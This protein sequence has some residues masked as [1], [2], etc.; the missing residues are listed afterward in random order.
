MVTKCRRRSRKLQVNRRSSAALR[1]ADV[2]GARRGSMPRGASARASP[3]SGSA[4]DSPRTRSRERAAFRADRRGAKPVAEGSRADP[5]ESLARTVPVRAGGVRRVP[6]LDSVSAP[7]PRLRFT[8]E[9]TIDSALGF[10]RARRTTD[11]A[12]KRGL[13]IRGGLLKMTMPDRS[14][15]AASVAHC[16][17][18]FGEGAGNQ[19]S[20][21]MSPPNLC[22]IAS[23]A[24]PPGKP[25]RQRRELFAVRS[26]QH[27]LPALRRPTT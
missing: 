4:A 16:R 18:R 3:A 19:P 25:R 12:P 20:M 1:R 15:G 14:A 8:P 24:S 27:E 26:F 11:K 5:D 17:D 22:S 10:S 23:G 6:R 13:P 2:A 7:L 9:V 21:G